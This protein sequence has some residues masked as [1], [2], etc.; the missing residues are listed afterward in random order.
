MGPRSQSWSY[1]PCLT[2]AKLR[3][4]VH[5]Y[6]TLLTSM[7]HC[8]RTT[9]HAAL[10]QNIDLRAAPK[11]P[12]DRRFHRDLHVRSTPQPVHG[13]SLCRDSPHHQSILGT[14]SSVLILH[15]AQEEQPSFPAYLNYYN[16]LGLVEYSY[17]HTEYVRTWS[18]LLPIDT[19]IPRVSM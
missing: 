5:N 1:I 11:K 14:P 19:Y 2:T 16:A 12:R 18:P 13:T 8:T 4:L 15:G 7:P 3:V 6:S 10:F 9:E 17:V